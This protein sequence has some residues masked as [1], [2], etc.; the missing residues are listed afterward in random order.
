MKH[1]SPL[2]VQFLPLFFDQVYKVYALFYFD[3]LSV[4]DHFTA[5]TVSRVT[6]SPPPRSIGIRPSSPKDLPFVV[7]EQTRG[8]DGARVIKRNLHS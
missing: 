1:P 6:A 7:L 5:L 8:V 2:L 3:K 4:R